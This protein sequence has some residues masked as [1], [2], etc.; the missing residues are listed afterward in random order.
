MTLA[1]AIVVSLFVGVHPMV[2]WI[3]PEITPAAAQTFGVES[4]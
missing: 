4:R 2:A 1:I 3:G